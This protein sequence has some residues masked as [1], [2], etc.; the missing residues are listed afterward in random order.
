[1]IRGMTMERY[2]QMSVRKIKIVE[3]SILQDSSQKYPANPGA[4][5]LPRC[6]GY[7][8]LTSNNQDLLMLGAHWPRV[9]RPRGRLW[10]REKRLHVTTW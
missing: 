3:V 6:D 7:L 5:Q 1:M 2:V 8:N 10:L 4:Y 9:K